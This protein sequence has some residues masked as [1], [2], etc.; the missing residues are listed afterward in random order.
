MA[1]IEL[2]IKMP[3]EY[4]NEMKNTLVWWS[5]L[6]ECVLNG[7]PLPKHH[8]DLKDVSTFSDGDTLP[9]DPGALNTLWNSIYNSETIIPA[10]KEGESE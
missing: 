5:G 3:E 8:G 4:Y 7:V 9:E 6:K 10:T 1:D 2:V